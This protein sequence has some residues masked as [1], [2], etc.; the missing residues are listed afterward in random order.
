[1]SAEPIPVAHVPQR[2]TSLSSQ[3][4]DAS[5]RGPLLFLFLSGMAWLAVATLLLLIASIKLHAPGFLAGT[6]WLTFGRIRQAAMNAFLY[7]F[8]SQTAIG[9][10][11]WLLCRLGRTV[12]LFRASVL[13]GGLLWNFFLTLGFLG[14]LAG[15]S[16]GFEWLEMPRFVPPLLFVAYLFLGVAGVLTF[17]ARREPEL[18]VSQWY[19]L[20]A[21]FWFPWIYS[22]AS[23]LLLYQPVRGVVQAVVNAWFTNNFLGLWLAPVGLAAIYYFIPKLLHRPLHGRW[24]AST[25]FW[26]IALVTNWTGLAQLTGGPLPRWTYS[27]SSAANLLIICAL[28]CIGMNWHYTLAG[29]YSR[30]R[31]NVTFQ[32]IAFSAFGFLLATAE[33]VLIGLRE[34]SAVTHFTYVPL[35][36][37][38]LALFGF[39]AMAL[40]GSVYYIVPRLT[41]A[42]WPRAGWVRVHFWCSAVGITVIYLSLTVGGLIQGIQ[43]NNP[44]VQ[45]VAVL[46]PTIPFVGMATTGFLVLLI[47]QL[48][49][50]ANLWL[51]LRQNHVFKFVRRAAAG[52]TF[53][54]EGV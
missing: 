21:L 13:I 19:L 42:G 20:A 3:A 51:V 25:G 2:Q 31:G 16:T 27:A 33:G 54:T 45:P 10:L 11:L 24:L 40:F 36:R 50:G 14:I 32:F 41:L 38:F 29:Q 12:L 43:W 49:Y 15:A 22:A 8:A 30:I 48:L 4:I 18:Y 52:Q 46:R 26:I 37:T 7:G 5:C 47:G 9:V 23:L 28:I 1:M 53:A 39:L 17:Y 35:A 34:V 6:P 44:A